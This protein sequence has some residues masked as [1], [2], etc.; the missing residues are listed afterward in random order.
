MRLIYI[1]WIAANKTRCENSNAGRHRNDR[2]W[3]MCKLKSTTKGRLHIV[4]TR[5]I[6]N[7]YRRK[8]KRY[9]SYYGVDSYNI[10]YIN[11][12]LRMDL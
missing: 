4:C 7:L 12:S 11:I 2:K 6:I 9:E 5:N 8:C 10:L 3:I 1:K